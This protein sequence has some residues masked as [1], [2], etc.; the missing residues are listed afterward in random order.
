M[1]FQQQQQQ[2]RQRQAGCVPVILDV[3]KDDTI[4]N[5]VKSVRSELARRGEHLIGLF[6]NAGVSGSAM[7]IELISDDAMHWVQDVN[8]NGIIRMMRHFLPLLREVG[9]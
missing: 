7:P 6:N 9:R 2:Q 8:V 5:A 4:A 1:S 3:C